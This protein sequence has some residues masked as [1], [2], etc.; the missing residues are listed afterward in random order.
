MNGYV[1]DASIAFEY[2]LG[3]SAGVKFSEITRG[4][5]LI[6]PQL[7]DVEVM[8]TLRRDVLRRTIMP[9]RA[10]GVLE[11]L[12]RWPVLR[13]SHSDLVLQA[14][15]YHQNVTAYDALYLA[16]AQ[17]YGMD[18]ITSDGRLSRAPVGEIAVVNV[19]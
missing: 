17:L 6:A 4:Q 12:V 10:V 13:I 16:A 11:A 1:V 8:S 2:L 14:W 9:D 15:R 3:T 19:R 7:I 18:L 5:R